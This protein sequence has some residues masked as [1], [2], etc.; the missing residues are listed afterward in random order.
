MKPQQIKGKQIS[1]GKMEKRNETRRDEKRKAEQGE[2][3][4]KGTVAGA[5]TQ[6]DTTQRRWDQLQEN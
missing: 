6:R 3:E 2:G 5:A 1:N 4:G